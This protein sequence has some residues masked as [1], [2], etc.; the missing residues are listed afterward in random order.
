MSQATS[1]A[2]RR[3][4]TTR[5]RWAPYVLLAPAMV[6]F[7]IVYLIPTG[8]AI[9]TSLYAKRVTSGAAYGRTES[10]FVGLENYARTLTDP[11]I[12]AGLGRLG[13]YGLIAI[14]LTMGLALVF[15]LALDIRQSRPRDLARTAIFLPYAVPGVIATMMWGF[16]YLPS[17]SPLIRITDALG[18]DRV[19]LL[20][21]PLLYFSLANVTIWGSV[22][23]NM[24]I[25]FTALRAVPAEIYDAARI[26]GCSELQLALRIKIPMLA[27]ALLLTGFFS[28]IGTLQTYS[29]PITLS[30]ITQSISSSFFPLMKVYADAFFDDDLGGAAATSLV[31]AFG[32]LI[33]SALVLFLVNRRAKKL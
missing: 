24:I 3:P 1:A 26:D 31:L 32:T 12:L 28:L 16:L 13:L 2:D 30:A 29:E 33:L 23:F 17:L 4:V 19:G 21:S 7:V 9:W 18:L 5:A 10:V 6:A 27:P 14:P 25:L 8:Y 11:D 15:A 20:E 22:G